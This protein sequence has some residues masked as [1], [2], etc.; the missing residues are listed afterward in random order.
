MSDVEL[1][2]D[3]LKSLFSYD[4]DTGHFT[5]IKA[6]GPRG[7]VGKFAGW[8]GGSGRVYIKIDGKSYQAHRLAWLY[9]YGQFPATDIDHKNLNPQDNRLSNLRIATRSQNQANREKLTTNK[10]G[11]KG[12]NFHK[13]SNKFVAQISFQGKKLYLGGYDTPEQAS[14]I[15]QQNAANLH[16]EF[17]RG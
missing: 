13:A 6:S 1:T 15:Y 8:I 11:F 2:Q 5:R 12:V 16:G 9:T 10:C 3:R 4:A 7:D 14:L 17:A